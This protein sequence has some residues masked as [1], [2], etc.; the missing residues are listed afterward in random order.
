MSIVFSRFGN[1]SAIIF[2]T[3]LCIPYACTSSPSS[4][5]MILRLGL[6]ID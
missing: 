5:P 4:M 2:L 3:I 1:F 6:L